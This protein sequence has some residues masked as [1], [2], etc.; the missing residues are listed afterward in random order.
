MSVG[1]EGLEIKEVVW[2]RGFLFSIREDGSVC[3]FIV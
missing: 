2:K 1:V 3:I